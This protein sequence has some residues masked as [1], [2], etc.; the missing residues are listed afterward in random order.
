MLNTYRG[1]DN[2]LIECCD[3]DHGKTSIDTPP[4][5]TSLVDEP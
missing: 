2:F 1:L 5:N 4:M 3:I